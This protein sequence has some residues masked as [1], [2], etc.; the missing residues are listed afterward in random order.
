MKPAFRPTAMTRTIAFL[1]AALSAFCCLAARARVL[2]DFNDN[3]KTGW[4]DFTF[5]PGFGLPEESSGRFHFE[6]PPAGQSIFSAS[7]NTTETFT[8]TEGR[9]IRFSVDLVSGYGPDSFAVLAFVPVTSDVSTLAGYSLAKSETDFLLVKGINKYFFNEHPADPVK[10][11]NVRLVLTLTARDGN[12]IINGRVLDRDSGDA[13]IFE[14]TVVDTPQADALKD[15]TDSPAEPYLGEGRFALY[16]YQDDGNTQDKYEIVLDNA[17]VWVSVSV[18]LDDF[19]DNTK[20]AWEDFTFLPGLGAPVEQNGRFTFEI[21]P[22]GQTVFAA[23]SRTSPVFDLTD[24]ER[25]EFTVDVVSTNG[26]DSF[27]VLGFIPTASS[28]GELAGYAI[29]R[30]ATDILISKGVGKYFCDVRPDVPIKSENIRLSLGL[31][32][33]D[34]SVYVN[35]RV[36]DPADNDAVLFDFTAVDT[37][38]ADTLVEGTDSPAAPWTG[39][40]RFVLIGFANNGTAQEPYQIVFDNAAALRPLSSRNQPP[41]ITAIEPEPFRNFLPADAVIRFTATDDE[42]LPDEA[43]SVTLNGTTYTAASGLVPSGAGNERTVSLGGLVPDVSWTAVLSVTDADGAVRTATVLFD[44]FSPD[45]LVIEIEDFNFNGGSFWDDPVPIAEGLGPRPESYSWQ[46]GYP[47]IDYFDTRTDFSSVPYRPGD[48]VRMQRSLDFERAKFA[49]AGGSAA[50]VYDYDVTDLEEG[51]WMNYTR[52]FPP[53]IYEVYLR[54][55]VSNL[56]RYE[57]VLER[58]TGN[59][60]APDQ[61][62]EPLGT[63]VGTLTGFRSANTPLTDATGQNRVTLALAG[64]QTLRLRQTSTIPDDAGVLQNYLAFIRT[65]TLSESLTITSVARDPA[66]GTVALT[67]PSTPDTTYRIESST[68]LAT[69]SLLIPALPSQGA[70]TTWSHIPAPPESSPTRFYRVAR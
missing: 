31:T 57:C 1:S 22:V 3:A 52:T 29:A 15:G 16:L 43:F 59:P 30:S 2:D 62:T 21:P 60:A 35:G 10:N 25:I 36:L 68:N 33:R 66:T 6:Q 70:T 28:V 7:T 37:P 39:S 45:S 67:W 14:Q 23:S 46:A 61:T 48:T 64:R 9:T 47:E 38:G 5:V 41:V 26:G 55:A 24:G 44:T 56:D 69:W 42:P 4:S 53:G 34:G 19:N 20:T 12:V 50:G 54:Q 49:A 58:V 65:G 51:E 40:G 13:V 32:A 11:E 8:L 63:F 17:E 27:A 18:L